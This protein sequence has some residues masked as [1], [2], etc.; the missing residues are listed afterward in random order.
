[1]THFINKKIDINSKNSRIRQ[2]SIME[3]KIL[4]DSHNTDQKGIIK[5]GDD[6]SKMKDFEALN[7]EEEAE[8]NE[9]K[10]GLLQVAED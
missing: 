10:D 1:M 9:E 4:V 3:R 6:L 2:G 7:E 8:E 5:K